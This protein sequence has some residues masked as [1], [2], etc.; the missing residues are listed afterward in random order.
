MNNII[1]LPVLIYVFIGA[2]IGIFILQPVNDMVIYHLYEAT[3]SSTTSWGFIGENLIN[4]MSGLNIKKTAYYGS[5]GGLIGLLVAYISRVVRSKLDKINS[6]KEELGQS[7]HLLV[8]QAEGPK[9]EFKS[10]FRWDLKENRA[11]KVLEGVILKTIAGFMNSHGGS[12]LIGV[13][14][15]GA[16][17]GLESDY[18]ILKRQDAD[19]FEQAIITAISSHLGTDLCQYVHLLI[20]TLEDKEICRL[21]IKPAPRPVYL[22]LKGSPQLYLRTGGGTRDLNIQEATE[23]IKSR[24]V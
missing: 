17:I 12:L 5:V 8:A 7:I 14:D 3:T 22:T 4:S 1:S 9:L 6:L 19:G 20:H 18:K 2:L 11:N 15:D 23:Y 16:I 24:W 13:A 10:S 21:I